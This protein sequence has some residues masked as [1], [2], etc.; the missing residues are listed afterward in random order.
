MEFV[1]H[2]TDSQEYF[3]Q[4]LFSVESFGCGN[5]RLTSLCCFCKLAAIALSSVGSILALDRCRYCVAV[6]ASLRVLFVKLSFLF[7][8]TAIMK[9]Y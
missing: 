4:A 6:T 3:S 1:T 8:E 7:L 9:P 2:L 5:I